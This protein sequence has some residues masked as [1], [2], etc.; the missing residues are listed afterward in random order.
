MQL[1]YSLYFSISIYFNKTIIYWIKFG[2]IGTESKDLLT[3]THSDTIQEFGH[4]LDNFTMLYGLHLQQFLNNN[5]TFSNNY[6]WEKKKSDYSY[7]NM[8]FNSI[9]SQFK[10]SIL[11]FFFKHSILSKMYI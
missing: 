3:G 11:F 7:L 1:S 4:M 8:N 5:H 6:F 2:S 9:Q 10:H